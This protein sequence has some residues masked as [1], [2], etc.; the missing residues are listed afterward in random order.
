MADV[1]A[2]Q[3]PDWM[4]V[5]APLNERAKFRLC[6]VGTVIRNTRMTSV[7]HRKE[8]SDLWISSPGGHHRR[9]AWFD[10][11]GRHVIVSIGSESEPERQQ[12]MTLIQNMEQFTALPVGSVVTALPS[13]NAWT[14]QDDDRW[15]GVGATLE[16]RY[17]QSDVEAGRVRL[18]VSPQRGQVWVDGYYNYL[19]VRENPAAVG[20]W[21]CIQFYGES[22]NNIVS[23]ERIP[24]SITDEHPWTSERMIQ[25][26]T[27]MIADRENRQANR[28]QLNTVTVE[29]DRATARLTDV[30][31]QL[32]G[33]VRSHADLRDEVNGVLTRVELQ[34]APITVEVTVVA[35]ITEMKSLGTGE[36][37]R[38]FISLE[39][40]DASAITGGNQA[41]LS[42]RTEFKMPV[43]ATEGVCACGQVRRASA[44]SFLR[45]KGVSLH[46]YTPFT[47]QCPAEHCDNRPR[48]T[49]GTM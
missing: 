3:R 45:D 24:G 5:G 36:E 42:Y 35:D 38:Q 6:P 2:P 31:S 27:A 48:S 10:T 11:N 12:S 15:S 30:Q 22:Y 16:G 29:R 21:W 46:S 7:T 33:F 8:R 28:E 43:T 19:I 44:I 41:L 13:N 32:H 4:V 34:P 26:A 14:K 23:V 25:L 49:A 18:G 1:A 17:F 39:P 47:K 40:V 20:Q 9:D 37:L